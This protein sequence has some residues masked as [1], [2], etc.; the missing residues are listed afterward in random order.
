MVP[1]GYDDTDT[2]DDTSS[3]T[4]SPGID[5]SMSPLTP[6][7]PTP[8]ANGT[9]TVSSTLTGV[10]SG[11]VRFTV[12]GAT[13]TGGGSLT[14]GTLVTCATPTNGQQVSFTLRPA[15]AGAATP[16]TIHV[17]PADQFTELNPADDSAS[18]TLAPDVALTKLTVNSDL[19]GVAVVRAQ[20]T[21][22]PSGTSVV[23]L[24]LSG[25]DDW[26][27]LQTGST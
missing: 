1:S 2:S 6:S 24:Q 7:A 21:G 12:S 17:Q 18:T 3:I 16:V 22:V 4:A 11:P 20:I 8:A 19:L 23:R 15:N 5:L 14:S 9:Y 25:A 10:R 27:P 13:V 26:T